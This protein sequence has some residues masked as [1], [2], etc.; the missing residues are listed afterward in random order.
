MEGDYKPR[1]AKQSLEAEKSKKIDSAL[2]PSE[3][4]T[5]LL[6]FSPVRSVR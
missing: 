6:E 4:N 1:N 2:E 3:R 5:A